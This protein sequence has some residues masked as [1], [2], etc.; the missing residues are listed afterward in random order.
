MRVINHAIL[1]ETYVSNGKLDGR[2]NSVRTV[3]LRRERCLEGPRR[4]AG[5]EVES[6]KWDRI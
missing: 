6:E 1:H 4:R 5:C 3:H 2:A